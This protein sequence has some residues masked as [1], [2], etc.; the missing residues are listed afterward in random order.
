MLLHAYQ[1]E[2]AHVGTTHA[3]TAQLDEMMLGIK[4]MQFQHLHMT[5][6]MLRKF[7]SDPERLLSAA[8]NA[9]EL[10]RHL[11]STSAHVYNGVV[12]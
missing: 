9:L 7:T 2:A 6:L 5:V 8:R 3:G 10:L 1:G 4:V 11:I 12:W